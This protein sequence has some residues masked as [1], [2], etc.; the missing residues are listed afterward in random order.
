MC[1]GVNNTFI[2]PF[3][4]TDKSVDWWMQ[5]FNVETRKGSDFNDSDA[6]SRFNLMISENYWQEFIRRFTMEH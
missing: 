6:N 1:K 5:H 4:Y 3:I 2:V